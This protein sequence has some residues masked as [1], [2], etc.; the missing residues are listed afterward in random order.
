MPVLEAD[1]AVISRELAGRE[2][3]FGLMFRTLFDALAPGEGL[4][5]YGR[6]G[7]AMRSGAS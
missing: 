5:L 2:A 4:H 3:A 1:C 6:L 7:C